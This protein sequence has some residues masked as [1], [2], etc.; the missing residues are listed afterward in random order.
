MR[1]IIFGWASSVHVQRW[2]RGLI[3]RGHEVK[4]ISLGG[5]PIEGVE[6]AIISRKSR[7]SYLT[8][9]GKVLRETRAFGP[10][11]VHAHYATGFAWWAMRT[12]VRPCVVSVWGADVM[13][14][15]KKPFAKVVIRN[16]LRKADHITATSELLYN[17]CLSLDKDLA[18]KITVVPFGVELPVETA[19]M[20]PERPFKLCFI[21]GHRE[22][23][24][25]DI[26]LEAFARVVREFP[27]MSLTM[28]GD[29]E[30]TDE[31]KR[32]TVSLG[33]S[34]HVR[35]T[36][37]VDNRKIYDLIRDHHLMLMPSTLASESFGVAVIEAGACGRAVIASNIGG[38]PEVVRD[39]VTGLL[40]PPNDVAALSAEILRL[41]NDLQK[42]RLMGEAG[43]KFVREN[44]SWE[45]SLDQMTTLYLRLLNG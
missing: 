1:I 3:E 26:L 19:P 13:D 4:V 35:F 39:G 11:I 38:I 7:L 5:E 14:F 17:V 21:K 40:V 16:V 41:A 25:P 36:G 12:K 32:M 23:Y 18:P 42:C 24:G 6:T 28:A 44:Y 22:K 20:P 45:K 27:E 30:M 43:Y 2:S 15:V 29:G 8:G 34:D 33:L 9:V 37:F 10:D 31:L